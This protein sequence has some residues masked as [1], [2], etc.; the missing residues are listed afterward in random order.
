M[1]CSTMQNRFARV[2]TFAASALHGSGM[3]LIV[4]QRQIL[5]VATALTGAAGELRQAPRQHRQQIRVG[6]IDHVV[7]LVGVARQVVQLAL[8][9]T[10]LDIGPLRGA[11][12]VEISVPLELAGGHAL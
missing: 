2:S 3:E 9:G 12:P 5:E 8:A 7:E 1:S 6:A 4:A 10:V 11:Q